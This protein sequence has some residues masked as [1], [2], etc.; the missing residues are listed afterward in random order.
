MY[1]FERGGFLVLTGMPRP[2]LR[3]SCTTSIK[4]FAI[5]PPHQKKINKKNGRDVSSNL[6]NR[7]SKRF[8]IKQFCTTAA[9]S[10]SNGSLEFSHHVSGEYFKQFVVKSSEWDDWLEL[11]VFSYNNCT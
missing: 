3:E 8:R 9:H 5:F 1:W 7:L 4:Y 10:Q 6:L 11:T 2:I